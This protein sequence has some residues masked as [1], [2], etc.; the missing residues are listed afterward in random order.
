[1]PEE[2]MNHKGPIAIIPPQSMMAA[3]IEQLRR[4]IVRTRKKEAKELLIKEQKTL[5]VR[6]ES[7]LKSIGR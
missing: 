6:L 2:I 5:E 1:M 7:Y 4:K 3:Q